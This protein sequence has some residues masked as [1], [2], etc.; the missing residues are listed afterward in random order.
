MNCVRC[1]AAVESTWGTHRYREAGLSNVILVNVEIRTCVACGERELVTPHLERLH[2]AIARALS[3]Q[4]ALLTA[5]AVSFLRKWLG[6]TAGRFA[7]LMG[8][9]IETIYRWERLGSTQ[10]MTPADDHLLKLLVAHNLADHYPL[11]LLT[12]T[13][14]RRTPAAIVLVAP[15]WSAARSEPDGADPSR[16][17]ARPRTGNQRVRG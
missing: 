12:V 1:G 10:T 4:T 9:R 15:G 14:R 7:V 5:E 6:L 11:E 17:T 3:R 16:S 13:E 8:V 2:Q